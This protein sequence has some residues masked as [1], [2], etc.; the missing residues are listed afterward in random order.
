MSK[1]PF[2]IHQ[3][4]TDKIVNAIESG[5][6]GSEWKMPWHNVNGMGVAP[7]N[8]TN[9][10]HYRGM[11]TWLLMIEAEDKGYSSNVWGT[12]KAWEAKGCK[13]QKGSKSTMVTFWKKTKYT[14]QNEAGEDTDK[15]GMFLRYYNVFNA[16]QVEGYVA[17]EV[18][19]LPIAE[20]ID[21]AEA[22]FAGLGANVKHGGNRA[23]YSS[24]HDFIQLP[25]FEQ[26]KDR[27][28]YYATSG[29]EHVHWTSH[30]SRCDR[31][32]GRRFGDQA[33]AFE[34]LVAELGS[35]FLCA[36][37]GLSNEPRP[38]HAQYVA[39]WLTVLKGDKKAVFTAASKAQAALDFLTKKEEAEEA[40]ESAD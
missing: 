6:K 21:H 5:V 9:G 8:V 27:E 25:L 30:K 14:I 12:Y 18:P 34:E 3:V 19:V 29:H 35:A 26:F 36:H 2:D 10:R 1:T 24:H 32:L 20:R 13:V 28:S 31:E 23:Y 22:F 17:K 39:N 11:N 37:L 16:D 7:V 15:A 4:I 40:M 33:Y 38:D